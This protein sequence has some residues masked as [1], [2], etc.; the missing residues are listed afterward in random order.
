MKVVFFSAFGMALCAA[1]KWEDVYRFTDIPLRL[2]IVNTCRLF[3]IRG[4]K[5]E[6]LTPHCQ[7]HRKNKKYSVKIYETYKSPL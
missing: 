6:L 1:I 2:E 5:P 7:W 4:G 3:Y